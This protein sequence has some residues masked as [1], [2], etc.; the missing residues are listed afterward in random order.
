VRQTGQQQL[1]VSA[2]ET[3]TRSMKELPA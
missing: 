1:K 3:V 2:M